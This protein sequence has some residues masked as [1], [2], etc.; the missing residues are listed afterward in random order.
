MAGRRNRSPKEKSFDFVVGRL[1]T[2]ARLAKRISQKEMAAQLEISRQTLYAY[3]IGAMRCP[4]FVLA[5]ISVVLGVEVT[6]LM[7][8]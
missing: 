4:V 8:V 2:E 7:P 1:I 6:R 3:E 5:R